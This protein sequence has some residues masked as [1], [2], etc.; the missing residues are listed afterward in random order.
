MVAAGTT[1]ASDWKYI[2]VQVG[3]QRYPVLF[4]KELVHRYVAR[5]IE[6]AIMNDRD[7]RTKGIPEVVSAGFVSGVSVV[8]TFGESESLDVK[9]DPQDTARINDDKIR[10]QATEQK[11][12]PE[13]KYEPTRDN[14]RLSYSQE[15]AERRR[16]S[17]MSKRTEK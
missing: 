15:L 14:A 11:T 17:R 13:P 16:Q 8:K 3:D 4:P 5:G 7:L 10:H 6:T 12:E 2:M 9:A 1:M